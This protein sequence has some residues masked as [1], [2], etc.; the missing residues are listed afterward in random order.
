MLARNWSNGSMEYGSSSLS[1]PSSKSTVVSAL[2]EED[3][4]HGDSIWSSITGTCHIGLLFCT[5][6]L[7]L[8]TSSPWII[9]ES[10]KLIEEE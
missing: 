5:D 7:L 9:S 2:P 6:V 4:M 10:V 1:S 8:G 3:W